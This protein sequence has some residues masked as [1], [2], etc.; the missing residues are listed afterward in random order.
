MSFGEYLSPIYGNFVAR[1]ERLHVGEDSKRIQ[2]PAICPG[3]NIRPTRLRFLNF[4]N[5]PR[6]IREQRIAAYKGYRKKRGGASSKEL[7]RALF[8]ALW[9]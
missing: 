9:E 3:D 7:P 4:F 1:R 8:I 2:S 5:D 6:I